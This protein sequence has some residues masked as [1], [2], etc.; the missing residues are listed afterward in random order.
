MNE[1]NQDEQGQ[2]LPGWCHARDNY[3][4]KV[5]SWIMVETMQQEIYANFQIL[6]LIFFLIYEVDG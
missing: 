3:M 6:A 5:C 2:M 1:C 4:K